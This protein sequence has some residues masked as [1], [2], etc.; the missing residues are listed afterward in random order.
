M[1]QQK[2][3]KLKGKVAIV[4]G[5][6]QGL[7]R[8]F[9]LAFAYEGAKIVLADIRVPQMELVAGEIKD[10]GSRALAVRTEVSSEEQVNNLV[11][12]TLEEL[13]KID[14]LVNN[15]GIGFQGDSPARGSIKDLSLR[16]WQAVLGVNLTGTFLCCKAVIK[17]MI[18]RKEGSIINLSGAKGQANLGAYCVSKSGIEELTQVLAAE[19]KGFNIRVNAL[20]PGGRVATP[21]RITGGDIPPNTLRPEVIRAPAI[22]LASD[23]SI[24]ITGQVINALEWNEKHGLGG[25]SAFLI[26]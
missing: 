21:G 8:E 19:L 3:K 12:K 6:A 9:A 14:V 10:L 11:Q 16:H 24:R 22:Y 2:E 13:G 18:A 4:T 5:A 1:K 7:G 26:K 20:S 17:S 15:A 23:D 25:A